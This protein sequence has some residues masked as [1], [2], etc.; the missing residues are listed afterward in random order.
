[1]CIYKLSSTED[2][3]ITLKWILVTNPPFKLG[4]ACVNKIHYSMWILLNALL[5]AGLVK[6]AL[7]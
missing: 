5:F 4:H 6:K 3:P 1:M 7:C 2:K